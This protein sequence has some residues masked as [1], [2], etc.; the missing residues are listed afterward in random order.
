MTLRDDLLPV[1]QTARGVIDGLGFRTSDVTI[2]VRFWPSGRIGTPDATSYTVET[3]LALKNP[4]PRVRQLSS[5]EIASS[6]G[7]Y[8][9]A[10]VRIDKLTP[11]WA[12]GGYTPAQLAPSVDPGDQSREV[13]YLLTGPLNGEYRLINNS[14]DRALGYSLVVRRT[15]AIPDST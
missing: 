2:E 10:D 15:R 6:G 12:Q 14:F 7:Q 3:T 4:R 8:E 11:Q 13:V 1:M 5:Q 9:Q